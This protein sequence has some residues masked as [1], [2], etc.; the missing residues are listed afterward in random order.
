MPDRSLGEWLALLERRHPQEIELGLERV[1]VVWRRLQSHAEHRNFSD[2]KVIT[3]AG[4]NGKGSCVAA[5]QA[6]ALQLGLRCGAF[7]SPHLLQYNERICVQ[8]EP[9]QDDLIVAAFQ[10]IE[11]MRGD[12]SLT[13]FEFNTL[14][15]LLI[16]ADANL[17]IVLLEVGLGG[18]LDAVNIIDADVAVVTSIAL[19][20]QAWLGDTREAIAREKIGIAR[21][22][23]PLLIG[24]TDLSDGIS[25]QLVAT[26]AVL[27]QLGRDFFADPDGQNFGIL[28]TTAEGARAINNLQ[29]DGILPQNIALAAQA[30]LCAGFDFT[31]MAIKSAFKSLHL[32]A[33]QQVQRFREKQ[34]LLDV[35]HN[36][37]AAQQLAIRLSREP[38][39]CLAV[40]SVLADKDWLGMVTALQGCIDIWIIAPLTCTS[41]A[42]SAQSMVDVVYNAGLR[43]EL[44]DSIENA[45][46]YAVAQANAT[47][48]VVV[49]GSF[50]TVSAV[51][52]LIQLE[53]PGE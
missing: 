48:L 18:R 36:P 23:R 12:V 33:R 13:Y 26:G 38:G 28:L 45:F 39:R 32:A 8:S 14:A 42:A 20:H 16:F 2:R 50:F 1:A 6:L 27:L 40:V 49:F 25:E 46:R 47:D 7:T 51:L 11:S 30:M 52:R 19:D 34:I 43:A 9:V 53:S 10:E 4:T 41:R 3:V 31:D 17:D 35:A 21:A 5:M 44:S 24:E 22:G 15:A 37:A 29:T